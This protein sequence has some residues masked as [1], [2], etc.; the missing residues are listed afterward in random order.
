MSLDDKIR[1]AHDILDEA[2]WRHV[3]K[4]GKELRGVV[5]LFSGGNDSTVL[6]HLMRERATHFGHCNTTIGI[7][8]TRQFVRDTA[9]LWGVEL[10]EETATG[11]DTYEALVLDQGFPG[12]GHHE[13][14]FQ[15]LKDHQLRKI[16]AQLVDHGRRQRV[17]FVAGR[18][19][20]E[21]AR[22]TSRWKKG[23]LVEH[24]REGSVVY[25]SPLMHW[26]DGDMKAYR[27]RFPEI[28]RNEV[29]D[30]IHMSGE[31]LCGAFAGKGE[32]EE[33]GFFFPEVASYIRSL[34]LRVRAAGHIEPKCIWGWGADHKLKKR[35]KSGRLCDSCDLRLF[36]DDVTS[37]SIGERAA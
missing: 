3:D 1:Q 9:A 32:L 16:R 24:E 2:W 7:E 13:K 5:V 33:I 34:E 11:G 6:A 20:H 21:S 22:R 26:T 8:Q 37:V 15:R 18:R 4:P 30:M 10:I 29:S 25:A 27:E 19:K 31:C 36:G 14:M 12:P 28:P 35:P 17:I 23:E